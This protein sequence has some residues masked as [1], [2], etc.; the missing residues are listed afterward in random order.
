MICLWY[1]SGFCDMP[2]VFECFIAPR[3]LELL[4]LWLL[5]GLSKHRD[6][7]SSNLDLPLAQQ[8]IGAGQRQQR[9]SRSN[10]THTHTCT[11]ARVLLFS[12]LSINAAGVITIEDGP[13]SLT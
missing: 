2:V 6:R 3:F 10:S 5:E 13:V 1:L 8:K 7:S 4:C 11:H 9:E 12:V